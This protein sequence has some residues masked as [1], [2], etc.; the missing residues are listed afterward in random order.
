[1][2]AFTL[3]LASVF[4]SV[5]GDDVV[6][7]RD[8][9]PLQSEA[10]TDQILGWR[11]VPADQ[12]PPGAEMVPNVY[13]DL[14]APDP[15]SEPLAA[16]QWPVEALGYARAWEDSMGAEVVIAVVDSGID[17]DHPDLASRIW[18]NPGETPGNGIDDDGNGLVDDV[19][20][21]DVV[22]DDNDPRDPS[23]G[24]G[25][26]VAGVAAAAVNGTGIAG[27]APSAQIMP[28]RACSTRCELFDVAW[29]ITYATDLG[30]DIINLSLGGYAQP[31]PLADAIDHAE[32]AGVLVVT[33]A[34]NG[35]VDIDGQS[36]VPADLPNPNLAAVASTDR[37]ENLWAD[38][39]YGAETVDLAAPGVD[40]VTTT[41]DS[42]GGYRTVTGTSFAAPHVA[43]TAALLLAVD[44]EMGP[45]EMIDHMGRYGTRL[46]ALD[47]RTIHGTRIQSERAVVA[48]GI[49]DLATSVFADDVLWMAGERITQGCNPPVDDLF[50]PGR[51]VSRGEMAAFLHRALGLA[52]AEVSFTDAAGSIFRSDISAIAAAGITH[53][54]NPPDND[55]YCPDRAITRGEMAAMLQRALGLVE[56]GPDF[57]DT[58][59]SVFRREIAAIAAAGITRGCNPPDND[60]FCPERV[61]TRGEMAAFL[62]R[63]LG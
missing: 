36:F 29:A 10:D 48:A 50:C 31:G 5:P 27:L 43:A 2:V 11:L 25:T 12:V 17:L 63:A 45:P 34:G 15:N 8:P 41:L 13:L 32:R 58:A 51:P 49:R 14:L 28:V 3:L 16:E 47:G 59:A 24:H 42:L 52:A 40:I 62:H 21:W 22:D 55:L 60:L 46:A 54:C 9:A 19:H 38:S 1:M 6:I 61:V 30:A 44:P 57:T 33:A 53:G 7:V 26:E 4:F 18:A 37:S 23:V 35:G 56:S 39:N 20:G